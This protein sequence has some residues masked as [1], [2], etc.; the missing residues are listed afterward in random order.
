MLLLNLFIVIVYV[1]K[2]IGLFLQLKKNNNGL[3]FKEK[4]KKFKNFLI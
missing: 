4:N 3:L 1:N 2:S